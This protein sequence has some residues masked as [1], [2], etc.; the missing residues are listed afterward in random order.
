[1]C[2]FPG[3]NKIFH[4]SPTFRFIR[5]YAANWSDKRQ[6][7]NNNLEETQLLQK[8]GNSTNLLMKILIKPETKKG[9]GS[10]ILSL[11]LLD[12][13]WFYSFG[14]FL[15]IVEIEELRILKI[16]EKAFWE[17]EPECLIKMKIC[18]VLCVFM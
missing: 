7:M 2:H 1:M 15:S 3:S 4:F 14:S 16:Y 10:K 6:E 5:I 8:N 12:S 11:N 17:Q 9:T 13:T 18:C